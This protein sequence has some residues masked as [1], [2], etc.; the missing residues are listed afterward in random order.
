VTIAAKRIFLLSQVSSPNGDDTLFK[1]ASSLT[2]T[3]QSKKKRGRY[4][5]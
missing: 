2:E 5:I 3:M 4:D 1:T